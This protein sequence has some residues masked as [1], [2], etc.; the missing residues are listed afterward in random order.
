MTG[1]RERRALLNPRVQ[2][3]ARLRLLVPFAILVLAVL[4]LGFSINNILSAV[5][6][7]MTRVLI[8]EGPEVIA[9]STVLMNKVKTVMFIQMGFIV[10]LALIL[11]ALYSFRIFGPQVAIERHIQALMEGDYKAR[12]HLR[13]HDEFA[14]LAERLNHLAEVLEERQPR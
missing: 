6:E 11:W 7:E 4:A 13:R 5:L 2:R 9:Q 14:E 1:T 10:I 3:R 12:V 8:G